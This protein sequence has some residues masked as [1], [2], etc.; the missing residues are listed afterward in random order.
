MFNKVKNR[1]E[2]ELLNFVQHIEKEHSLR[3]I[4]PLLYAHIKNFILRPGKRLRPTLFVIGYKAFSKKNPAGL[5]TSALA[6]ELLHDF[7]LVHDDIIDK[8]DTRRGQPSM[9]KMLDKHLARFHN[10]KFNGQDLSIALG[11]VMYAMAI[12]AF[13]SIEED[14]VRKEKALRKFIQAAIV[15]GA[16]EFLELL[17]GTRKI[18]KIS[19]QDI[20][21][22]YDYKTAYYTFACPLSTGAI[23]AGS[24]QKEIDKLFGY[25]IYLGR[26]FQIKDDILGIFGDESKIGKSTLTDLQEAKK[27]L[28]IWY[29]YT[30][31][32][33]TQKSV[34]EKVFVK[35]KITRGDLH[36]IRTI[37]K[38]SG[39]LECAKSEVAHLTQKAKDTIQ[40]SAMYVRYK[41]LL[42]RY[43]EDILKV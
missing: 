18:D 20:Y 13:L 37:I 40:S 43:A 14:F 19:K 3:T 2:K 39:A 38:E 10:I 9:H 42:S 35:K 17:D 31:S 41:S 21:K 33:K 27:T 32:P 28:L 6:I 8:S 22:I 1:I 34:I 5:Y 36:T 23:L 16:G 7:M 15:T 24:C 30:R 25:G 12:D 4:S 26:A 11:D 29:A